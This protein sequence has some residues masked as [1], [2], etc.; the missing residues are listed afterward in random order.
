MTPTE[1][2]YKIK[3]DVVEWTLKQVKNEID[4]AFESR[5]FVDPDGDIH[6]C[7][8]LTYDEILKILESIANPKYLKEVLK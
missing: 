4:T 2:D 1:H 8:G 6:E 5:S 3:Q 7:P